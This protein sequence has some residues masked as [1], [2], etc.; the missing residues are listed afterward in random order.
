MLTIKINQKAFVRLLDT[1]TDVTVLARGFWPTKWPLKHPESDLIGLGVPGW[2]G[3]SAEFLQW[4]DG[5]GKKGVFQL[6][7]ADIPFNY[8]GKGYHEGNECKNKY[9]QLLHRKMN[10]TMDEL[11]RVIKIRKKFTGQLFTSYS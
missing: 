10:F 9:R 4:S 3:Q 11:S 8:L 6:Y 1:G 7:V 5:E 2:V